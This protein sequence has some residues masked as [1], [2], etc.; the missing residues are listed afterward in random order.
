[1]NDHNCCETDTPHQETFDECMI[2]VELRICKPFYGL[3]K[4]KPQNS[5]KARHNLKFLN[6]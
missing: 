2:Q 1:M 3:K 4:F 5:F 6:K